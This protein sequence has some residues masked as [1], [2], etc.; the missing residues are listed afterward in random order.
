MLLAVGLGLGIGVIDVFAEVAI[1]PWM[2]KPRLTLT[3]PAWAG[4]LASAGAGITEEIWFRFGLMTL[5]VWLLA[6]ESRSFP[7]AAWVFWIG[8]MAAALLF[9]AIHLPQAALQ[10]GLSGPVLA[11]VFLDNGI[12]GILF[13]WFYWRRGLVAAMVCHFASDIIN[14]AILPLLGMG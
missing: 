10:Y 3:A 13:G 4:L 7:P 11:F 1:T 8:N 12:A 2:P 5:F 9:G 14:L 6:R